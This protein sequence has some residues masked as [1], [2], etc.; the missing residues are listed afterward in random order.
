MTP[1]QKRTAEQLAENVD[2][3]RYTVEIRTHDWG[4]VEV[5]ATPVHWFNKPLQIFVGKRG[6]LRGYVLGERKQLRG[7]EMRIAWS[8]HVKR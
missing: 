5:Y 1:T 8:V 3:R 6:G 2:E 4:V 7:R